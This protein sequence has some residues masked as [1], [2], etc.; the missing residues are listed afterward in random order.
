MVPRRHPTKS[1]LDYSFTITIAQTTRSYTLLQS[2]DAVK[3]LTPSQHDHDLAIETLPG[4][5]STGIITT[6][7]PRSKWYATRWV[8]CISYNPMSVNVRSVERPSVNSNVLQIGWSCSWTAHCITY[9]SHVIIQHH[10][11]ISQQKSPLNFRDIRIHDE[12]VSLHSQH[13]VSPIISSRSLS[14][15]FRTLDAHSVYYH[16]WVQSQR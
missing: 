3:S 9:R 14:N 5:K 11:S 15:R 10:P 6:T 7:P 1:T 4:P 16:C 12:S 2:R 13:R 8:H